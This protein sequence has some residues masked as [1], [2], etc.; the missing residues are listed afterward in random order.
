MR[1]VFVVAREE[2]THCVNTRERRHVKPRLVGEPQSLSRAGRLLLRE[3]GPRL[4]VF[5]G[6][7]AHGGAPEVGGLQ[8]P[9]LADMTQELLTSKCE[10]SFLSRPNNGLQINLIRYAR[11]KAEA[12]N[13][14][15]VRPF[16][17]A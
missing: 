3:R 8:K 2:D 10:R 6:C 14:R 15:E 11:T 17:H 12:P 7:L 16:E 9:G 4:H 5:E 13:T 1:L